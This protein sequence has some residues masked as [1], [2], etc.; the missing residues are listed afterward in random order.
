MDSG[1]SENQ[2]EDPPS[3]RAIAAVGRPTASWAIA[4]AADAGPVERARNRPGWIVQRGIRVIIRPLPVRPAPLAHVPTLLN[5]PRGCP[6][7]A[8]TKYAIFAGFTSNQ[9]QSPRVK[10][11][12]MNEERVS[13]AGT[14]RIFSFRLGRKSTRN[15]S[16]S[17]LFWQLGQPL[18]ERRCVVPT[19]SLYR[20]FGDTVMLLG[21]VVITRPYRSCVTS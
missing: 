6:V 13:I 5:K 15:G 18:T 11:A 2:V 1:Y 19:Y 16:G 9:A 20:V 7:L 4:P 17:L 3:R 8:P 10:A 14:V 21:F 12:S